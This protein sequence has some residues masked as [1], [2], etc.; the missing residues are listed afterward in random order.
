MIYLALKRLAARYDVKTIAR[1][2]RLCVLDFGA[3]FCP[4]QRHRRHAPEQNRQYLDMDR[5]VLS[6]RPGQINAH[7]RGKGE[8]GEFK[9]ESAPPEFIDKITEYRLS[10]SLAAAAFAVFAESWSARI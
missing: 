5:R 9:S 8:W 2:R 7:V 3:G 1:L 6:F 10:D 4:R